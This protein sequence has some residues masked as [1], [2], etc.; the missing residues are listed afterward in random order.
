MARSIGFKLIPNPSE[1]NRI[2]VFHGVL[3][4]A[5]TDINSRFVS[6]QMFEELVLELKNFAEFVS[7][8]QLMDSSVD[9]P[10]RIALTFDD[11]Y[12]NNY[13]YCI[14]I[15]DRLQVP[16]T[17]FVCTPAQNDEDI[18]WTDM[19]D[20]L[21]HSGLATVSIS[22]VEYRNSK[23]GFVSKEGVALKELMVLKG[24]KKEVAQLYECWFSLD[25]DYKHKMSP[26]WK[27]MDQSMIRSISENDL[28][29]V[30]VH[31]DIHLSL[32][33]MGLENAKQELI[34]CKENLEFICNKP[35][36][37]MAYPF[38][39]Y[40][41]ELLRISRQIGFENQ[42][43]VD[44]NIE[45]DLAITDGVA[46]RLGHNPHISTHNQVRAIMKGSY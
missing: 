35:I 8:Q 15:L 36:T 27:L 26:Y 12:E 20:L 40:R 5:R 22:G 32:N 19:V 3:P 33:I 44:A 24:G 13:Q 43:L 14:P 38:G 23:K 28:F 18:L 10:F 6:N 2:L 17:F 1:R 37:S 9:D 11:G 34:R 21:C 46:E 7:L 29:E 41:P 30:G 31:G 16:A 4:D 25:N 42:L 39:I 45:E